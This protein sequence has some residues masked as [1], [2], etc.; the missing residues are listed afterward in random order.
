MKKTHILAILVIAVAIGTL[1]TSL[2]DSSTYADFGTAFEHTGE[3]FHVVGKLN[4]E[5]PME[6][7]PEQNANLFSFYMV[8]NKGEEQKVYLHKPKPQ[9]FEQSEQIVLI[10]K[11]ANGEFHANQVLMKCPSKYNDGRSEFLT[12]EEM[13]ES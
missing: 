3:E 2:A 4:M 1:L 5:K 7:N 13:A 12:P 6:Y 8:D 9:D 11:A 10:G